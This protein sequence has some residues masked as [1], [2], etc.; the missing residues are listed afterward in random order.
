MCSHPQNR[1]SINT[2]E[3]IMPEDQVNSELN[4]IEDEEM[5][6]LSVPNEYN[7]YTHEQVIKP[8]RNLNPLSE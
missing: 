2:T 3:V 5:I 7:E 4:I 1:L 8:W 6:D